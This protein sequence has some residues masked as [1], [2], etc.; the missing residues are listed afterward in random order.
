MVGYTCSII[1][2]NM[3]KILNDLNLLP[4]DRKIFDALCDNMID[5]LSIKNRDKLLKRDHLCQ[6]NFL[7]SCQSIDTTY[8]WNG[9]E[10][11]IFAEIFFTFKGM[12][13]MITNMKLE[14]KD[15]KKKG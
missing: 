11:G 1:K 9:F 4:D 15:K 3:T 6:L 8:S 13:D 2:D 14:G 10:D 7:K 5:T 12:Q